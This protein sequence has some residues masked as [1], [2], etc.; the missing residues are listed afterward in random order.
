MIDIEN[1]LT[2]YI[3]TALWSTLDYSRDSDGEIIEPGQDVDNHAH[4]D[5]S[6]DAS[7]LSDAL[8]EHMRAEC[9]EFV[10][11]NREDIEYVITNLTGYDDTDA[12]HDFWLTREH[13]GAGFW[14]R[15]HGKDADLRAALQRLTDAADAYGNGS[16]DFSPEG[17]TLRYAREPIA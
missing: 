14:D 5:L 4:L 13:H 6:Y 11:S 16:D 17:D 15:Y 8:R 1:F 7:D 2:Q 9:E 3:E 10:N 12:A